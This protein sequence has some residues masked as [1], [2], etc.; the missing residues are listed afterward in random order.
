V[1]INLDLKEN[2]DLKALEKGDHSSPDLKIVEKTE[3]GN[4]G[5]KT[6]LYCVFCANPITDE[7]WKIEIQGKNEYVFANPGGYIFHINTFRLAPGCLSLGERIFEH[8]WFPG[9]SWDYASCK[10]CGSHLGWKFIS[11][12]KSFWGLIKDRLSS[13]ID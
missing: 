6:P 3:D 10:S 9:Y 5:D 1:Y 11:L 8:T 2:Y 13:K 4:I 12:Q 7:G